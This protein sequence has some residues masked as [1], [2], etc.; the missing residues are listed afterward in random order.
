MN[1]PPE[2][3]HFSH[4]FS[5]SQLDGIADPLTFDFD[6]T[7]HLGKAKFIRLLA[8]LNSSD[9][10]VETGTADGNMVDSLMDHFS[11]IYSIEASKERFERTAQKFANVPDVEIIF[12]DS[13]EMLKRVCE[14]VAVHCVFFLDAHAAS[15][16]SYEEGTSSCPI[17]RE[18][19][20]IV[21]R[22]QDDVILIDDARLL[23]IGDGH[24]VWPAIKNIEDILV[25]AGFKVLHDIKRDFVLA[26]RHILS[27]R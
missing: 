15:Q 19:G 27:G 10:L 22:K 1:T 25:P 18:L 3:S 5:K 21:E 8:N 14:S 9:V 26:S 16:Y 20:A 13:G 12:G 17:L 23:G 6:F 7:D 24:G 11:K 2:Y 4:Q